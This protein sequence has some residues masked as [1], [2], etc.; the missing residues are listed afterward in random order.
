MNY[1]NDDGT[2]IEPDYYAPIIPMILVNGSKGI[3]TG[4]S[5]DILC[6]NPLDI[7]KYLKH[8]LLT[9]TENNDDNDNAKINSS[10]YP[11]YTDIIEPYY[12]G[13]TGHI[14]KINDTK[15]IIKGKY[16]LIDKIK[17]KIRITELPIG[18]WT[19]D[20][21][22]FLEDMLC[23]PNKNKQILKDYDDMSKDTDVNI[24]LTL[25]PNMFGLLENKLY[26]DGLYNDFEKTF[27]LITTATNTNMHAFD[28]NNKLKKYNDIFE[29]INDYY[30]TR[31]QLY[32]TRKAYLINQIKIELQIMTNKYRYIDEIINDTIIFKNK[33]KIQIIDE[34]NRKKYDIINDDVEFKYLIKMPIDV[35]TSDNIIKL[36]NNCTQKQIDYDIIL[37]TSIFKMWN[38]DLSAFETEYVKYRSIRNNK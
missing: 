38:T 20:Y 3:G 6:Y 27:K 29:I 14:D 5:T 4:F 30:I 1:L 7:V 21:K 11:I 33:S 9:D 2:S 16:E 19:D 32:K 36:K 28:S 13:F 31:L 8:K 25:N 35:L 22:K 23:E 24:V 15:Y 10:I 26:E 12:E 37:N 34:L 17:N 18:S